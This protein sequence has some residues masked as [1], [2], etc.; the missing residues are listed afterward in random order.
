[1]NEPVE[2]TKL[3]NKAQTLKGQIDLVNGDLRNLL[4]DANED[5]RLVSK[6]MN[7]VDRETVIPVNDKN[8]LENKLNIN[9]EK[10]DRFKNL[11]YKKSL[12]EEDFKFIKSNIRSIREAEQTAMINENKKIKFNDNNINN[13]NN[14]E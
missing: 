2:K 4:I 5:K 3:K 10:E 1:M 7:E 14:E 12:L 9:L 6:I 13:S 11:K 8:V